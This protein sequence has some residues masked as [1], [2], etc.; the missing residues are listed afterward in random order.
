MTHYSETS[1]VIAACLWEAVLALRARPIT[2]P[3][4]IGLA[5]AIDKT[6]DALG[7][8]ALRLTVVGWT[9]IVEAAWRGGENDYPLCFDWDFVPA[10][11][12]DHIDWSDPFHPAVIQRGG[13]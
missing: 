8:A 9:D 11:I 13:G 6:F 2:D 5:L 1:L 12:I 4:A 10:W 7:S 3:D